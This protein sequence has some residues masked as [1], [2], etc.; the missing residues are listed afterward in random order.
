MRK[1]MVIVLLV[2]VVLAALPVAAFAQ[3]G[4]GTGAVTAEGDGLA[5]IRGDG[6]VRISGDGVLAIR[7]RAGDAVIEISGQGARADRG[8]SVIYRGFN[9]EAYI[10]GSAITVALRGENIT[11][12]AEG[13]GVVFL[14]GTGWYRFGEEAGAWT[15]AGVRLGE[16][17][18]APVGPPEITAP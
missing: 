6:W 9:G 15:A 4:R 11:L 16:A 10:E 1:R 2:V 8:Q 7:D 18:V 17:A 5:Y 13:A 12:E 14:C 3:T